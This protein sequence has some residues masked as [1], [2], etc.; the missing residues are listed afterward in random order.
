M[1]VGF[2]V[3]APDKKHSSRSG[4]MIGFGRNPEILEMERQA[5]EELKKEILDQASKGH[6][7][8]RLGPMNMRDW[9]DGKKAPES[10]MSTEEI[11]AEIDK[12]TI[13]NWRDEK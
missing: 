8:K 3:T 12:P 4:P 5:K 7:F 13:S 6:R 9:M 2:I 10:Y 11:L 1:I